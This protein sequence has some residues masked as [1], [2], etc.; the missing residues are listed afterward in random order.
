MRKN[1][2]RRGEG[3][4]G[5]IIGLALLVVVAMALVKIVPLHIKGNEVFDAMTEAAN[6]AG[7]KPLDKLAYEVY[8]KA[9]E[10]GVPLPL[11]EI[12]IHRAGSEVVVEAKYTQ[13][14]TVLGY[15][16]VYKFDRSVQKPVF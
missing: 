9:Q 3:A 7:V 1:G 8:V 13:S 2:K 14:V 11:S 4:F 6:F 16:Y 10:A 5:T 12:K 15:K